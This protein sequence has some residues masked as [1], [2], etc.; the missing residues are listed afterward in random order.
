MGRGLLRLFLL[1]AAAL[2]GD[3]PAEE[4]QTLASLPP[5]PAP[6]VVSEAHCTFARAEFLGAYLH[7]DAR[8]PRIGLDLG[9]SVG[10]D[11]GGDGCDASD[12]DGGPEVCVLWVE[13]TPTGDGS[14]STKCYGVEEMPRIEVALRPGRRTFRLLAWPRWPAWPDAVAGGTAALR[15]TADLGPATFPVPGLLFSALGGTAFSLTSQR[16]GVGCAEGPYDLYTGVF[17]SS[18]DAHWYHFALG[19]LFPIAA[20][21]GRID[22]ACGAARPEVTVYVR[23]CSFHRVLAEL[24]RDEATGGPRFT[25]VDVGD[26]PAPRETPLAVLPRMDAWADGSTHALLELLGRGPRARD[27]LLDAALGVEER[28]G[29]RCVFQTRDAA[30]APG[31]RHFVVSNL[32]AL[33]ARFAAADPTC[34]TVLLDDPTGAPLRDQIADHARAR[35]LVVPHGAG[36]AHAAW[37]PRGC[38]VV[39]VAPRHKRSDKMLHGLAVA[40]G[41]RTARVFVDDAA[42]GDLAWDDLRAAIAACAEPPRPRWTRDA[43]AGRDDLAAYRLPD[44]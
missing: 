15:L 7:E 40:F 31:R 18:S 5:V 29:T 39:E 41:L 19:I 28:D 30:A 32:G 14:H 44:A 23:R 42:G 38:C 25:L 4:Q 37:A 9:L 20:A 10:S 16:E 24:A 3:A 35:L 43:A 21:L 36:A 22:D 17:A 2:A 26:G 8:G 33:A 34:D 6:A 1:A 27:Y 13:T 11:C 12:V